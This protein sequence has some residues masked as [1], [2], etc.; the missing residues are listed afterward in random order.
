MHLTDAVHP[1]AEHRPLVPPVDRTFT[2][3]EDTPAHHERPAI[4]SGGGRYALN[5]AY[6]DE[7][8]SEH[9]AVRM[10]F[11][12]SRSTAADRNDELPGSCRR[13]K[14]FHARLDAENY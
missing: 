12:S 11:A 4:A 8:I 10:L 2:A 9:A 1:R 6:P 7:A 3:E 14:A 5:H 13:A